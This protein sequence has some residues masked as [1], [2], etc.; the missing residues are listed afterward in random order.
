M[1]PQAAGALLGLAFASGALL[2]TAR[3]SATG[4]PSLISRI[5]PY[6]PSSPATV[7]TQRPAASA[8]TTLIALARPTRTG[9]SDASLRARLRRAGRGDDLDAFRVEQITFGALG[10]VC[11]GLLGLVAIARGGAAIAIVLL[12]L[13]GAGVALLFA[14]RHLAR[15]VKARK[16]R[17]GQ[18][19]PVVAELLAFAVAAGE[20]PVAAIERVTR[21]V[22]GDL[23]AEF[24][25]AMGELRA[26]APLDQ[27][28]RGIAER[29]ASP[30]VE[31]FVDG[32]IMAIERG[33]P[34]A[35]VL[36]AQAADA[37]AAGRRSLMEAAGR[38][39]VAMLI[40]VV[41]LILPTVVL[42]A[43]FPGFQSLQLIVR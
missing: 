20:S 14:D 27:A 30:E 4:R 15:Q 24:G 22:S 33:T 31:R 11:G 28:L 5:A 36:R 29:T 19:L 9:S 34:M 40:P 26:G 43:L 25:V 18:Q 6:V 42:I 16:A 12:P 8:L 3:W 2:L 39:D 41:F 7:H 23:A 10:I 38:K 17:M 13:F 35:E 1:T 32:L 21:T 37:R